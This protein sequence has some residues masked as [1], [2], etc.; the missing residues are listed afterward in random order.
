MGF[1]R[2]G[3]GNRGGKRE[4]SALFGADSGSG[5]HYWIPARGSAGRNHMRQLVQSIKGA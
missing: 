4:A 3:F 2:D 5:K 1:Y